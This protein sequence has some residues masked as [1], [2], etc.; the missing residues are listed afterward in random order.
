MVDLAAVE[1][2][3]APAELW[4][5]QTTSLADLIAEAEA[6]DPLYASAEPDDRRKEIFKRILTAVLKYHI[7][8][9]KLN[10]AV[11]KSNT[12]YATS[13][14]GPFGALDGQ[15]VRLRIKPSFPFGLTVNFFSKVIVHDIGTTNGACLVV[16][17]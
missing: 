1:D 5:L 10:S 16:T 12:T 13:L 15:P 3:S 17:A 14:A 8:P 2:L 9:Q 11:L 7:L 4:G 6:L